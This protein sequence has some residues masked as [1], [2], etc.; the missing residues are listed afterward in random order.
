[1]RPA[2]RRPGILPSLGGAALL[3]IGGIIL[4][5]G[6]GLLVVVAAKAVWK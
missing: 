1:M 4:S 2:L 5:C 6:V 3:I